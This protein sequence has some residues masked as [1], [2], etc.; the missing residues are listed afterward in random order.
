[1]RYVHP[2][3]IDLDK[4]RGKQAFD[5]LDLPQK[6]RVRICKEIRSLLRQK[7]L[8]DKAPQQK[9]GMEPEESCQTIRNRGKTAEH[10]NAKVDSCRIWNRTA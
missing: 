8:E 6:E 7:V 1:M 3:A 5:L 9:T 10:Y 4:T 2:K